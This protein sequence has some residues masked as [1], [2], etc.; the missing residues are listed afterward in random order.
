MK[1]QN[2]TCPACSGTD[3]RF[4]GWYRSHQH[5]KVRRFRCVTCARTFS[6][7]TGT[8]NWYLHND[9]I[10]AETL[11]YNWCMGES[12]RTIAKTNS[13]SESM[14]RTRLQRLK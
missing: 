2:I 3:I 8:V 7:R 6:D 9:T 4:H 5:G 10:A 13:C 1:H 14:I 12:I 11:L